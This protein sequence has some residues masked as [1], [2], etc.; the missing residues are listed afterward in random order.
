MVESSIVENKTVESSIVESNIAKSNII[1]SNIVES[2]IVESCLSK[3][4]IRKTKFS[5]LWHLMQM[6]F[7]IYLFIYIFII[8]LFFDLFIGFIYLVI[9]L[10]ATTS[11]QPTSEQLHNN[12]WT[13]N[14]LE[15][16]WKLLVLKLGILLISVHSCSVLVLLL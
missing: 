15:W 5:K 8:H 13:T 16:V 1:E 12:F 9:Y 10:F 3:C 11:L 7:I 4:C 6:V 2:S 14:L